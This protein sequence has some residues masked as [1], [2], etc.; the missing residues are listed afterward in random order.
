[1][2]SDIR[3]ILY[4]ALVRCWFSCFLY[5]VTNRSRTF[6]SV[7]IRWLFN[8]SSVPFGYADR[9][10]IVSCSLIGVFGRTS[11]AMM[12]RRMILRCSRRES[13]RYFLELT[14]EKLCPRPRELRSDDRRSRLRI[15]FV[16]QH[17]RYLTQITKLFG[18]NQSMWWMRSSW[19][20]E[21]CEN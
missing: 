15:L 21:L 19:R 16:A 5:E 14:S 2:S 20:K 12:E 4:I 9:V 8:D 13:P 6:G 1:M 18:H 3:I 17:N 11:P 7:R 10:I